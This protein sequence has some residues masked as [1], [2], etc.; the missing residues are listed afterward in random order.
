MNTFFEKVPD[1]VLNHRLVVWLALIV[2]TGFAVT[3]LGR[4]KFDMTIE[5]WFAD[6]DPTIVAMDGFRAQFGSDDHLYIIYKPKDGDVFSRKSLET[7]RALREDLLQRVSESALGSPLRRVV[8]IT[9][10]P[11]APVLTVENDALISRHLVGE[12][13]PSSSEALDAIRA[14]ARNQKSLPLQYFSNDD[15]Y[16]GIVVETNFGSIP[17][18]SDGAGQAS[19]EVE[20]NA[21]NF[22]LSYEGEDK[23]EERVRFEPTDLTE[24]L[25][26][27]Q[28]VKMTLQ[29]PEFANH[30]DYY[31]VGNPA[32]T[33]YNMEVLQ[34]MGFLYGMMMIIIMV[35][36]W[37]IFRSP[38]GVLWPLSI[39][40][41]SAIWT[42]GLS[43]WI[44]Y[45]FTAFLILSVVMILVIGIADA[46]HILSG[47]EYFRGK[48]M[49]HREALRAS[50]KSSA[51]PSMLTAVTSML[52]MLSVLLTPIQ[53]IRI[54]GIT[55]AL[56][57]GL[58]FFFTVIL[59]PVMIDFWW[60]KRAAQTVHK[61]SGLRVIAALVP[62]ISGFAQKRLKQ[63]FPYVRKNRIR[64]FAVYVVVQLICLY[65]MFNIEVDTDVKAQFPKAAQIRENIDIADTKM[66]GSQALEIYFDLG[67]EYAFHDPAV[68]NAVD[69]LQQRI[70]HE[71]SSYVV[72][73]LSLVDVAKKSYQVLN[74]NRPDM[75]VVPPSNAA[76]S[77]TLFMFD[78][79]NPE[80]RRKM[81][82]DD[83]SKSHITVYLRN[84][85]SKEYNKIFDAI[86]AD[87]DNT[88]SVL[89][90]NY[91]QAKASVTGL[92]TLM[93]QGA[94]YLSWS[95]LTGF[96][97]AVVTVSLILLFIF[98]SF[99]AGLISV[100]ANAVPATMTFGLMGLLEVPL[101]F[102]TVLIAPI[103]LG[104]AVDDT[105]HFLSHYQQEVSIDG[106]IERALKQ[107][108]EEVGLAVTFTSLI[109]ALGLSVLMLSSSVG[110]A[111]VG[112]YGAL[113]VVAGL[114]CELLLMPALVLIMSLNFYK[115]GTLVPAPEPTNG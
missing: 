75:Y 106:D 55:T 110:N 97:M 87:I 50:F 111:N 60:A 41:L 84:A 39:V 102:T 36:L 93:M 65:G 21:S 19:T 81:V 46:I 90:K 10:L 35:V 63:L 59:L 56:G 7:A 25:D 43:G 80:T 98:G 34:E 26:F 86:Q 57:I 114:V 61:R 5:G 4:T 15:R 14:T 49:E 22:D 32:S 29:K 77:Q 53:P 83:Y 76:L 109:L 23:K 85:G 48:G 6:D 64:I 82:S 105:I 103:V 66:M 115:R 69:K 45:T 37:F 92:F 20:I 2:L 17:V 104:I 71:Y 108:I 24:Y 52:A 47:Y 16:G 40:L 96:G 99:K 1:F 58:A 107:T 18:N 30:F 67:E 38:S 9:A 74:E 113:A 100:L 31:S 42:I 33:E 95:S 112:I 11:N 91:P 78:N 79:S 28:A 8:K 68:L 89:K 88:T 70:E 3:G 72:R 101:D 62:D 44:G 27:M 51:Y 94:D 12:N 54:F 13:V 73:T